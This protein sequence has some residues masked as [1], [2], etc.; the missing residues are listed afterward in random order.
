MRYSAPLHLTAKLTS[1]CCCCCWDGDG[2]DI[3]V[4]LPIGLVLPSEGPSGAGVPDCVPRRIEKCLPW[5]GL[6]YFGFVDFFTILLSL[7]TS[8]FVLTTN[9]KVNGARLFGTV[10]SHDIVLLSLFNNA[11]CNGEMM[12]L[13]MGSRWLPSGRMMPSGCCH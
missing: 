10:N 13:V 12:E 8:S 5:N 1:C 11:G 7:P 2:D 9:A 3:V 4:V 6:R